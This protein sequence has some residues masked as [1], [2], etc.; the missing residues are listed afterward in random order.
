MKVEQHQ[1]GTVD[2]LAPIGPLVD[3]DATDFAAMLNERVRSPNTRLVVSLKEVPYLDSV[4]VEG[5]L[6]A[7]DELAGRATQLKLVQVPATCREILEL[8]GVSSRFGLFE[9]IQDAVRSF[10]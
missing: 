8:T 6:D 5:F 4:A 9:D 2:V 7:T 3:Q 10:L 1:M